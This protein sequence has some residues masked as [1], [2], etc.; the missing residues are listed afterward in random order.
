MPLHDE[1]PKMNIESENENIQGKAV[2]KQRELEMRNEIPDIDS[3]IV[4]KFSQNGMKNIY[5]DNP[6]TFKD[7]DVF[8]VKRAKEETKVQLVDCQLTTVFFKAKTYFI[9]AGYQQ[10][11]KFNDGTYAQGRTVIRIYKMDPAKKDEKGEVLPDELLLDRP[12]NNINFKYNYF[13]NYCP[14]LKH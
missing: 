3:F 10:G 13:K 7:Q 12:L 14:I 9:L 4:K 11:Y 2:F 1:I 8:M 6:D 5:G